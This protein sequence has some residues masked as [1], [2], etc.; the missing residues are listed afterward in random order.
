MNLHFF[1]TYVHLFRFLVPQAVP[2]TD[3]I[4]TFLT[5]IAHETTLAS[6]KDVTKRL[7]ETNQN[8]DS[9]AE[10]RRKRRPPLHSSVS[11]ECF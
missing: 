5:T 9:Q 10:I 6:L 3:S 7:D 4:H 2:N 11:N 8:K 1:D